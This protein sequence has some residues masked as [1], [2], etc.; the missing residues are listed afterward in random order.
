MDAKSG[1]SCV[2]APAV[3]A[4]GL[5][6]SGALAETFTNPLLQSGPDPWITVEGGTYYF[7]SSRGDRLQIRKTPDIT[8]LRYAESKVVWRAPET[9]PNSA[10]IWAPELHRIDGKWFLYYTAVDQALDNDDHRHIFVLENDSADP[11]SDTWVDRGK[12]ALDLPGIDATV[13][14]DGG[15]LYLVYSAYVGP[16]SDLIIAEMA[17]PWTVS[18]R[19]VDFAKPTFDWEKQ[20]GRQILE[21]PEF[22]R[23]PAGQ[24][25]LTYSASACWSDDYALGMLVAA[26]GGDLLDPK[27]WTKSPVPVFHKSA[28]NGVYAPGHNG[29][30]KSPDGTEDWIVYHAN[31]MPGEACSSKRSPRIQKFTWGSDGLPAFGQPVRANEPLPA[32]SGQ[33]P[34]DKVAITR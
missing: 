23:G 20:G 30:F 22:L 11:L 27:T 18:G 16:D 13:F 28:A 1:I 12:I 5:F 9:G 15:K 21:G 26:P 6:I 2:L 19:Q 34:Q 17:N 7:T 8:K 25:V 32:P 33:M 3:L 14:E 24:R 4:C 10:G 29:F 31:S